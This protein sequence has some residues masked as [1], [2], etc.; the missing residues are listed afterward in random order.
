MSRW[1]KEVKALSGVTASSEWWH[2][3]LG[4]TIPT[5]DALAE[6]FNEFLRDLTSNF[7]P[8]PESAV[9]LVPVPQELLVY[10]GTVFSAL[11]SIKVRKSSGPDPVPAVVWKG[12][13][14]ELADV[15][16]DLYSSSLEQGFVPVQIKESI[17][18][19]LP[20]C[21]SPKSVKEDLRPITL[22]S[23]LAKV[24]EGFTLT[25]YVSSLRTD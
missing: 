3:M 10:H 24:M 23:H 21:N 9:E 22:T 19:P 25:P 5:V 7:I 20:K 8:L 18:H 17:V 14:F 13:A 11:R 16:K 12:F 1:S 6:R 2:Q 15:I 4:E